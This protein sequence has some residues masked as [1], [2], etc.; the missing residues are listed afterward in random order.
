MKLYVL[1]IYLVQ[2]VVGE[3]VTS[4]DFIMNEDNHV[5]KTC[6]MERVNKM[7]GYVCTNLNLKEVPQH[8]RS[9]LE[10]LDVSFNR[11]RELNENS[12][13]RYTDI[14]YLYLFENMIQTIEPNTF[15]QLT[16]LEAI[17]ISTNGLTTL[18]MGLFSLPL[19]RNV[20]ASDNPLVHLHK[21]LENLAKPISAP[22]QLINLA[23]CK[24]NKVP[25]FGVLP[26]LYMLNISSN[27]LFDV[28]PQQ[29]SPM[30]GLNSIDVNDTKIPPCQCQALSFYFRRRA[31]T[32]KNLMNCDASSA[33]LFNCLDISNATADTEYFGYCTSLQKEKK[34]QEKSRWT[35]MTVLTGL[36]AFFVVFMG[37]LYCFHRRNVKRIRELEQITKLKQIH[38]TEKNQ[39]IELLIGKGVQ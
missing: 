4:I 14:K 20:H 23:S 5:Q 34:L 21:D 33:E 32:V 39:N 31:I 37:M 7:I 3:A 18:P 29:F 15:A 19:L 27:E 9:G 35:W 26:D 1:L 28:T 6:T 13:A 17:D 22:L 10:I 25:D 30:C 12:F 38:Q 16:D 8:L 11:I 36:G 2:C 24:L